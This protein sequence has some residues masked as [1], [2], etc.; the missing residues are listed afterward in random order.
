[1]IR[2]NAA[3]LLLMTQL[4][5][6][7]PGWAQDTQASRYE[8]PNRDMLE[9]MVPPAWDAA[10]DQPDD[11]G[12]PTIELH[13]REGAPFEIY[14]T[15]EWP[16]PPDDTVPDAE[17]LRAKVRGAAERVQDQTVEANLEIRRMQG[18]SGVGFYFVA[19]ERTPQPEEFKYMNQGALQVG[20]LTLTFTILTND[21]QE[22]VVEEAFAML[23]TAVQRDIGRDQQ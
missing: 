13:A 4:A 11:G 8:L 12:S 17:T 10:V 9:L 18:A 23:R 16:D 21:G 14:I 7:S 3:I 22:A 6:Q 2:S 19:T 5:G 15:L 20:E 1:M